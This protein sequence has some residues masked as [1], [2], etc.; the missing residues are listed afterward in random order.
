MIIRV[1]E[2]SHQGAIAQAIYRTKRHWFDDPSTH[3]VSVNCMIDYL[4]FRS[5]VF[6]QTCYRRLSCNSGQWANSILTTLREYS[7]LPPC[8]LSIIP[9]PSCKKTLMYSIDI[10]FRPHIV[11]SSIHTVS[12]F[13]YTC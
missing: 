9:F 3:S 10:L 13:K 1:N 6:S 11:S 7:Y 8:Y 4:M 5:S 12:M 2:Y